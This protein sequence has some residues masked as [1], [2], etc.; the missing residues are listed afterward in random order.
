[1]L[2]EHN[3]YQYYTLLEEL[4][5]SLTATVNSNPWRNVLSRLLEL[6]KEDTT[7]DVWW[8]LSTDNDTQKYETNFSINYGRV[9]ESKN[10]SSWLVIMLADDSWKET[11]DN[12]IIDSIFFK[13]KQLINKL[14]GIRMATLSFISDNT[15][16]QHHVD[17][18]EKFEDD[19]YYYQLLL[20]A[21]APISDDIS[22]I[23]E[24]KKFRQQPNS[25]FGFDSH[26]PHG[27]ENFSG[28]DWI[29]LSI[30]IQ[31]KYFENNIK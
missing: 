26:Y 29:V 30:K 11:H 14:P 8:V 28:G 2:V 6:P 20:N 4:L 5:A 10:G 21:D 13:E 7:E 17:G 27:A 16:V 19:S 22:L 24:D 18:Y 9:N 23:I 3:N 25:I 1:M 12:E 31:R 15:V